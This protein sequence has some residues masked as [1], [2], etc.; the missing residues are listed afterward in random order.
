[1]FLILPFMFWIYRF[2]YLNILMA[3]L[4]LAFQ[5][6][7]SRLNLLA[8]CW[9]VSK[10]WCWFISC[11]S[12]SLWLIFPLAQCKEGIV[13][14]YAEPGAQLAAT[15][16]ILLKHASP[17]GSG[18]IR[19]MRSRAGISRAERRGMQGFGQQWPECWQDACGHWNRWSRGEGLDF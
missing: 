15:G 9:W 14:K 6:I 18:R 17:V 11:H 3:H 8:W 12:C 19:A 10:A 7:K 1:M 13:G 5:S 16:L 4:Q 2:K